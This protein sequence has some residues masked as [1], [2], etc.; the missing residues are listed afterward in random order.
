[1]IQINLLD[2]MIELKLKW[3]IW[4]ACQVL[5]IQMRERGVYSVIEGEYF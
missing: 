2:Q 4:L 5:Q 3:T 1:M